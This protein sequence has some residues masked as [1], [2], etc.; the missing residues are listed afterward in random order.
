MAIPVFIAFIGSLLGCSIAL[1]VVVKN[2]VVG[3]AD[4]GKKPF[5]YGFVSGLLGS[6]AA[7]LTSYNS[8]NPVRVFWLFGGIFFLFGI[9]H[10]LFVHNRYFNTKKNNSNKVLIAEILFGL[11]RYFFYNHYLFVPA[12]FF[13][14]RQRF[15]F[16][17][18]P[19]ERLIVLCA[20]A[21]VSFVSSSL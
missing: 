2:L 7:F 1:A 16:L 18:G 3:F 21:G 6:L 13:I 15:S 19:D 9:L 5:T 4:N 11:I 17:S 20:F 8:I 14:K 12:I 10:I